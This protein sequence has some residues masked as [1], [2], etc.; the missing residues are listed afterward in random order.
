MP[1][2]QPQ[3][4]PYVDTIICPACWGT[5]E[6]RTLGTYTWGS[7]A[8]TVWWDGV[9]PEHAYYVPAPCQLC[10]GMGRQ[11]IGVR[12]LPVPEWIRESLDGPDA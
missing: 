9:V 7:S 4:V 11:V 2:D 12:R 10:G 8:G 6:D 1:T 3:M 5:G